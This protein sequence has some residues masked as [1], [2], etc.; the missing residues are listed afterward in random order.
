MTSRKRRRPVDALLADIEDAG[1]AAREIVAHGKA[2]WNR[3]RLLRLAGE[4]VIGRIADA[5]SRLPEEMKADIPDVP[6]DD[7]RDIRILVDHIY[8][9]IDS[10]ALWETLREEVPRLLVELERWRQS[11]GPG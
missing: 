3:D 9:R 1:E 11:A 2:A 6:W 10:E 5:A 4:A 7:V 8:H